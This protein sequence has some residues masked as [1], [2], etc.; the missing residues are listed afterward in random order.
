[1]VN[2]EL[3]SRDAKATKWSLKL[4]RSAKKQPK[5][6][7]NGYFRS[8]GLTSGVTSGVFSFISG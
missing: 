3:G 5:K 4:V 1:M 2:F 7:K 6:A 8:K